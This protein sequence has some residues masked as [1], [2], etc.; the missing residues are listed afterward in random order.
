MVGFI[1]AALYVAAK[2]LLSTTSSVEDAML[3]A[4]GFLWYWYW[5]WALAFTCFFALIIWAMVAK[6]R[7]EGD[8]W[9][10]ILVGCLGMVGVMFF[11]VY[12]AV[13]LSGVY[14]ISTA[15][16]LGMEF[17]DFNQ[18]KLIGGCILL[19]IGVLMSG[20]ATVSRSHKSD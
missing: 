4:A 17:T 2:A 3:N 16:Q 13:L 1:L 7:E 18:R 19:L 14:L 5:L 12:Q 9:A 6:M 8:G 20:G 15:G 10:S 11:I